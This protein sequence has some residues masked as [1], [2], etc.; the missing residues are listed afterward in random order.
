MTGVD[1]KIRIDGHTQTIIDLPRKV[2]QFLREVLGRF[3]HKSAIV[4][5]GGEDA[6]VIQILVKNKCVYFSELV[7][8]RLGWTFELDV[9]G[10]FNF[11][12]LPAFDGD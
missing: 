6:D 3:L 10:Q 9:G 5:A 2:E 11:I 12:A 1:F 8:V 4:C 7:Q